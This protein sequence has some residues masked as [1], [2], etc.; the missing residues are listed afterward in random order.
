MNEA[1]KNE[2]AAKVRIGRVEAAIWE[3]QGE[4]GPWHSVTLS[5]T[6]ESEDG[7]LRSSSSFS[8]TDL[9]LASEALRLA[10]QRVRELAG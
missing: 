7:T 2:P 5:R 10:H 6:Y 8:G 1:K 4:R 9:L 3:N